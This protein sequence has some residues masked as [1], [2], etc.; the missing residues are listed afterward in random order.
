MSPH[1]VS[2]FGGS[3]LAPQ[4][5]CPFNGPVDRGTVRPPLPPT[6]II[7]SQPSPIKG[8]GFNWLRQ[9]TPNAYPSDG[10][11]GMSRLLARLWATKSE[12]SRLVADSGRK[13]LAAITPLLTRTTVPSA[14][15]GGAGWSPGNLSSK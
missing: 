3:H 14:R 2:I 13:N 10:S 1:G 8:E 6:R 7:P 5:P 12:I 9:W 15:T 4:H 11:A